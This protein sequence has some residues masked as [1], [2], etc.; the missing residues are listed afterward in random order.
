ME[1]TE[2]KKYIIYKKKKNQKTTQVHKVNRFI[3][4]KKNMLGKVNI[5]FS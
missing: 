4:Q 2:L 5:I 1:T 3:L